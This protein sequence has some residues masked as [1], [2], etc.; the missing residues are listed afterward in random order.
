MPRD[1]LHSFISSLCLETKVNGAPTTFHSSY[2]NLM[3]VHLVHAASDKQR[4]DLNALLSNS[5]AHLPSGHQVR[6]MYWLLCTLNFRTTRGLPCC[7]PGPSLRA[8]SR[9]VLLLCPHSPTPSPPTG[10][11]HKVGHEA[12]GIFRGTGEPNE[13]GK[14]L[15]TLSMHQNH[16]Q[17]LTTQL[18][19]PTPRLPICISRKHPSVAAAADP[20]HTWIRPHHCSGVIWR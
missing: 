18:P 19:G 7:Q 5:R 3:L 10:G 1:I 6:A 9:S 15:S 14:C 13:I 20:G 12:F 4:Q 8:E 16:L 2:E 11:T 17:G